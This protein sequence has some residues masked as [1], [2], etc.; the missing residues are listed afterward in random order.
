MNFLSF[1]KKTWSSFTRLFL[2]IA[3][4]FYQS[5]F[6][7]EKIEWIANPNDYHDMDISQTGYHAV[8]KNGKWGYI[9]NEGKTVLAFV[10]QDAFGFN[11][12]GV[13]AVKKND[14]WGL[15]DKDGNFTLKPK[16]DSFVNYR[17]DLDVIYMTQKNKSVYIDAKGNE[18]FKD[19]KSNYSLQHF[20]ENGLSTF[21]KDP[22][23]DVHNGVMKIP[24]QVIISPEFRWIEFKHGFI[25]AAKDD[26]HYA[27][28]DTDG[29]TIVPY[30]EQYL[31]VVN[32]NLIAKSSRAK[33][34]NGKYQFL[35]GKGKSISDSIYDFISYNLQDGLIVVSHRSKYGA[36]DQDLK[37]VIPYEFEWI[38]D[39]KDG[40][41]IA[42]KKDKTGIIDKRGKWI[43]PPKYDELSDF[44][45]G[46]AMAKQKDKYFIVNLKNEKI[47][48]DYNC[49]HNRM[50]EGF[51]LG[52]KENNKYALLNSHGKEISKPI[53]ENFSTRKVEGLFFLVKNNKWGAVDKTGK[54]V[55]PFIF[56][57]TICSG[58]IDYLCEMPVSY[59]NR[60]LVKYK[61]KRGLLKY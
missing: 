53:Y 9:D 19:L 46:F 14:K 11:K 15:I 59:Q 23:D 27:V 13:A 25:V 50:E 5:V 43:I 44:K 33:K 18:L 57:T 24:N 10:Y 6:S 51:F 16:Y 47:S 55:I 2:L 1:S 35:D 49:M 32:R 12:Q 28:Y 37:I 54:E 29:N 40:I 42:R 60:I 26:N 61:G 3:T 8:K 58:E 45:S 20:E 38:N 30:S 22:C 39:F 36:L 56:D 41:A 31:F 48:R 4:L 17:D 34:S 52:C 7:Q 21:C